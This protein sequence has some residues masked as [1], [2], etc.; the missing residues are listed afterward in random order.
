MKNAKEVKKK[1]VL[2]RKFKYFFCFYFALAFITIISFSFSKYKTV[3]DKSTTIS[4]AKPIVEINAE[5][6]SNDIVDGA[7]VVRYF[8][9]SNYN[10]NNATEVG[11]D[12]Y[13]Y[14]VN[15]NNE[16]INDARVYY[17]VDNDNPNDF[18]LLEKVTTGDYTGYFKTHGFTIEPTIHNYKLVID[19]VSGYNKIQIKVKAV[20]KKVN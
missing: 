1:R 12:Y 8:S 6:D 19:S 2:K 9:V 14:I 7:S 11:L 15:E 5:E 4:I 16:L 13:I 10:D 17:Q 3:I 20:Q 18:K